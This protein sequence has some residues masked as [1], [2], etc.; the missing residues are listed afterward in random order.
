MKLSLNKNRSVW[1]FILAIFMILQSAAVAAVIIVDPVEPDDGWTIIGNT[2]HFVSSKTVPYGKIN[3]TAGDAMIY[4]S[5]KTGGR[6]A[7]KSFTGSIVQAGIYTVTFDVGN[8]DN[9][10][11]Y[12]DFTVGLMANGGSIITPTTSAEPH[13]TRGE[14]AV[15]WIYTYSITGTS[16]LLGQTLGFRI[17]A[18]DTGDSKSAIFDNLKIDF[19]GQI[20][21]PATATLVVAVFSLCLVSCRRI[22]KTES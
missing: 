8:P 6:E 11:N 1:A 19:V 17:S 14:P 3:A 7:T 4:I 21:E 16:E 20:P 18:P 22:R 12:A 15:Q 9:G 5:N 13:P 2:N 10:Q